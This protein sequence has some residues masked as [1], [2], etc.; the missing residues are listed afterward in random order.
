MTTKK[1]AQKP[2]RAGTPRRKRDFPSLEELITREAI[3]P[4]E[5]ARIWGCSPATVYGVLSTGEL[6]SFVVGR[7]RF[8]TREAR[9]RF[10]AKRER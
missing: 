7:R 3:S 6:D 4:R 10:V 2:K 8:V 9:L 5:L 1:S